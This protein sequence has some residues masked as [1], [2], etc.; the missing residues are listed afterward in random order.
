MAIIFNQPLPAMIWLLIIFDLLISDGASESS[1]SLPSVRLLQWRG[2]KI[3]RRSSPL[4]SSTAS[5]ITQQKGNNSD[6]NERHLKS[7]QKKEGVSNRRMDDEGTMSVDVIPRIALKARVKD[8]E[9]KSHNKTSKSKKSQS[10]SSGPSISSVPS[11]S[12]TVKP[13]TAPTLSSEPTSLPTSHPSE[14]PTLSQRPSFVPS[15]PPTSYPTI[16]SFPSK[17]PSSPPSLSFRPTNGP[18]VQPDPDNPTLSY[19]VMN[20][21]VHDTDSVQYTVDYLYDLLL[22]VGSNIASVVQS[23]ETAIHEQLAPRLLECEP[24]PNNNNRYLVSRGRKLDIIAL[25]S[26]PRDTLSYTCK[27]TS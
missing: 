14:S 20:G 18:D 5:I 1:S 13:S 17:F 11:K 7:E 8:V 10:P 27:Y 23:V 21:R 22:K 15:F 6:N 12:P 26:N 4:L 19:C 24:R 25:D 16:S 9:T 2:R 3:T